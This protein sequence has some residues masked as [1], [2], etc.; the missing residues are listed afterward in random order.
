MIGVEKQLY[1]L[2]IGSSQKVTLWKTNSLQTNSWGKLKG[3]NH[4][5]NVQDNVLLRKQNTFL[6]CPVILVWIKWE[7][8]VSHCDKTLLYNLLLLIQV[9]KSLSTYKWKAEKF[10]DIKSIKNAIS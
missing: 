5:W 7:I 10:E 9:Q 4:T 1:K 2:N 6:H 8:F 3:V